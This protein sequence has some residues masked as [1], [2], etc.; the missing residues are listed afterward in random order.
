MNGN[1]TVCLGC[2]CTLT[3]ESWDLGVW[4][5]TR[6][7]ASDPKWQQWSTCQPQCRLDSSFFF[8]HSTAQLQYVEDSEPVSRAQVTGRAEFTSEQLRMREI[9]TVNIRC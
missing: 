5:L 3:F 2:K 9:N 7:A 4:G 1:K 8:F 6:A